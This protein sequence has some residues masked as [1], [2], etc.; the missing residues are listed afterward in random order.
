M[1][2]GKGGRMMNEKKKNG[3]RSILVGIEK[4]LLV[5]QQQRCDGPQVSKIRVHHSYWYIYLNRAIRFTVSGSITG[6]VGMN[7]PHQL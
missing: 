6:T 7:H 2:E 4:Q 3:S 1:I 5:E